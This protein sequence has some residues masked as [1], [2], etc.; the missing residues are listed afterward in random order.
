MVDDVVGALEVRTAG[1]VTTRQMG[2]FRSA[3]SKD[4]RSYTHAAV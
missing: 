1:V 4:I 3:S 2:S